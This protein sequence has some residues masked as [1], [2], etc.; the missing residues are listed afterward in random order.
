M[1]IN[2]LQ[3]IISKYFK[4][5]WV[6]KLLKIFVL[7]WGSCKIQNQKKN[8]NRIA[9]YFP[10]QKSAGSKNQRFEH[11]RSSKTLAQFQGL[12]DLWQ[13][14]PTSIFQNGRTEIFS[15]CISNEQ[16]SKLL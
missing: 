4:R 10:K 3:V 11:A 16:C 1:K 5:T 7:P 13:F 9:E 15:G 2:Q 12:F 8:E 6:G 14:A